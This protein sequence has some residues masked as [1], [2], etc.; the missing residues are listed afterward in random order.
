MAA[1]EADVL[2]MGTAGRG[3]NGVMVTTSQGA[4]DLAADGSGNAQGGGNAVNNL[5]KQPLARKILPWASIVLVVL[6]GVIVFSSL[7]KAPRPKPRHGKRWQSICL[8]SA[9]PKH[10]QAIRF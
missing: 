5:L 6:L 2:G 4:R 10:R 3:D 8:P 1:V 9:G 7:T